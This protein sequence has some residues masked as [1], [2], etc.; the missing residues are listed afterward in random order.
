[1]NTLK[2]IQ[3]L[4]IGLLVITLLCFVIYKQHESENKQLLIQQQIVNQQ[5]LADNITRSMSEFASKKDIETF[6]KNN[7]L[8]LDLIQKNLDKL[9]ATINSVNN[10]T[11]VSN[12][13]NV[14]NIHSTYIIPN[15]ITSTISQIECNGKTIICS[16]QD[17]FGYF[18][19]K[20]FLTLNESFDLMKVPIGDV[21]FSAWSSNPWSINVLSRVYSS[22]TVIGLD[23]NERQYFYNKF[24]IN[25]GGKEYELKINKANSIQQYPTSKFHFWNPKLFL[26]V[27]TGINITNVTP[28]IVPGIHIGVIDYSKFINKPILSIMQIGFAY[29]KSLN[30]VNFI[31][32]PIMYNLGSTLQLFSNTYIGP[33]IGINTQNQFSI[34]SSIKVGF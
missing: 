18:K 28:I 25:V 11:V 9:N 15:D 10:V 1:M 12:G 20:Q 30:K 19:N 13:S 34:F 26:G 27:D 29:D 14:S 6:A 16:N 31:L 24:A 21:G 17:K 8:N 4:F 22:T 23:E 7:G 3:T 33:S 32:S 5:Q 2:Q